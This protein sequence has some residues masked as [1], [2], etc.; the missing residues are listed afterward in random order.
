MGVTNRLARSQVRCLCFPNPYRPARSLESDRR[1]QR[2]PH[3]YEPSP[4]FAADQRTSPHLHGSARAV[5]LWERVATRRKDLPPDIRSA[6]RPLPF[7]TRD[8]R[9]PAHS[10]P[11]TS[12]TRCHA[13]TVRSLRSGRSGAAGCRL[14]G[15][16]VSV[17]LRR[18]LRFCAARCRAILPRFR[19][20]RTYSRRG[21]FR[22]RRTRR[23]GC[24]KNLDCILMGLLESG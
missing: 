4:P 24:E 22:V 10:S 1:A 12:A 20:R 3:S 5:D 15:A 23:N 18:T 16:S 17:S 2:V 7:P 8:L 13:A 19:F 14:L 11:Q 9:N 21:Y 6:G